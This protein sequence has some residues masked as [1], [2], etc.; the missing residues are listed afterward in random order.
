VSTIVRVEVHEFAFDAKN[1]VCDGL[2]QS[3]AFRK[4]A[5]TRLGKYAVSVHTE[6]GGRGDY[7]ALWVANRSSLGQTLLLAPR[8][9]G[10]DDGDRAGGPARRHL[11]AALRNSNYY[12]VALVGPDCPNAIPPVYRCGYTDQLDRIDADGTVP[13][14]TGVGLGVD[15]DWDWI[16]ANRTALHVFDRDGSRTVG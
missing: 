5:T 16:A 13:V 2:S 12:E 15:Y 8:L 6:D 4:G 11:M 1:L 9:V 10:K 3:V 7:V 14:P